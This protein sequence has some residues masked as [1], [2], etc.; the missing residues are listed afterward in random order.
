MKKLKLIGIMVISLIFISATLYLFVFSLQGRKRLIVSTTT[1]LYDTGLLDLIEEEFEDKYAI[2]I[3]FI[4][5]GTGQA[6]EY[7]KRGD[8]DLILV[9]APSAEYEFLTEGYG[10]CRKIIAYN[11]FVIVGPA[12]DPAQIKDKNV[13]CALQRIVECGHSGKVVWVSRGDNS[14]THLKEKA[15][16]MS[17]GLNWTQLKDEGSWFIESGTGMGKTLL[18]ANE[19]EAYTLSDIGTYLKYYSEG[20]IS[21]QILVGQSKGL[22]NVYSVMAVNPK[23]V[24]TVNFKDAITFIKFLI[25][26][27]CQTLIENFKKD[28]YGQNLFYPAVNL[29]KN[30]SD[31]VIADWI[32]E[33]AFFNGTECPQEYWDGHPEL[34][35]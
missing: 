29:L 11:F 17:A 15:L 19:K 24:P 12:S 35:S 20:R 28:E 2:D 5:V 14:G 4:S 27:E 16:W 10:V 1:S 31:S 21:L 3:S 22:L 23:K 26:E 7:A 8:A 18:I 34:Y 33:Y 32:K 13:T 25:S 9:H 30:D 6:I